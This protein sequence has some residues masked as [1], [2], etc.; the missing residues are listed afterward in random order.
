MIGASYTLKANWTPPKWGTAN[1]NPV[2]GIFRCDTFVLWTLS[3]PPYLIPSSEGNRWKIF[4]Q[5]W[6]DT[7]AKTPYL[8]FVKLPTF[9]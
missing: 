5:D 9:N 8:V 1:T 4:I 6:L 2:R 7:G 3:A